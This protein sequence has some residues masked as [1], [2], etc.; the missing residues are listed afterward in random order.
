MTSTG[1]ATTALEQAGFR[2]D[3]DGNASVVASSLDSEQAE[4][5]WLGLINPH[6][7]F[8]ELP[9]SPSCVHAFSYLVF[10]GG[11]AAVLRRTRDADRP[12]SVNARALLG[13]A[14]ELTAA[15]A[16]STVDWPHWGDQP[17][18]DRRL[19]RLRSEEVRVPEARD[20]LRTRALSRG[21]MLARSLAW[22]LQAPRTP[23]G[24]VGCP[25]EDRLALAGA[26]VEIAAPVLP[27]REWTFSTHADTAESDRP[28]AITFFT[29]P[30]GPAAAAARVVIDLTH[31][32]GA[33]PQNEYRA[34]ALVYRYEYGID[35]PGVAAAPAVLPVPAPVPVAAPAYPAQ[36]VP[37]QGVPV[38]STLPPWQSAELVRDVVAAR[39]A[40]ALDGA[41]VELE[42]AVSRSDDRDDV[43]RALENEGWAA[44]AIHEHVP[45]E[46]RDSVFDRIVQVAFGATGPGRVTPG[47]RADA[48]RLAATSDHDELVRAIARTGAASEMADVLARRWLLEHEPVTPDPTAGLGR[49]GRFLRRLG[50]AVTPAWERRVLLLVV[51]LVSFVLGAFLGVV[52]R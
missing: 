23:L 36:A 35:P 45:F 28:A 29:A 26:L 3:G 49:T 11:F 18:A 30:P 47:A 12:D 1:M 17:T 19:P 32:Q 8:V 14:S 31:D 46:L 25:E 40:R 4:L 9:D 41:L 51:V 16:L 20:R 7:G 13:P 34:N 2:L 15:V 10:P 27:E 43:R 6:L 42:Y 38:R 52:L 33:S 48:R 24:L 22:M 37:V 21:D 44:A 39:D 5:G 50:V